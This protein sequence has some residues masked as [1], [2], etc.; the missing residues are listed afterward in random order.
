MT[1]NGRFAELLVPKLYTVTFLRL[2][3]PTECDCRTLLMTLCVRLP[4][5]A[6]DTL[7]VAVVVR[8]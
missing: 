3:R 8:L 2:F 1:L 6:V 5:T 7:T 4:F